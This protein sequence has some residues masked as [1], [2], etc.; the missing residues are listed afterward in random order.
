[1]VSS[2]D[3]ILDSGWSKG[4]A[5]GGNKKDFDPFAFDLMEELECV[6]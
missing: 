2:I 3:K 1:M 5:S 6:V 4:F